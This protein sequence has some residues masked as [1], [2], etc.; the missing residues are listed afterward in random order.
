VRR[1]ADILL[2]VAAFAPA[3]AWFATQQGQGALVYYACAAGGP[4]IGPLIG[5]AGLCAC[6]AGGWLGW[7]GRGAAATETPRFVAQ[8]VPG[9]AALFALANLATLVA[10]LVIPPCAR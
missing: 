2:G 4:P 10:A 6:L 7:R 5:F 9:L 3:A 1:A 8:V